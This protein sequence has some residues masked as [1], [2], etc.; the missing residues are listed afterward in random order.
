MNLLRGG[1]WRPGGIS[2]ALL[3]IQL[4]TTLQAAL[5]G[6]DYW[7]PAATVPPGVLAVVESTAPPQVWAG[8]MCGASLVVLLGL[9]GRWPAVLI[10]G[11]LMLSAVYLGVGLPVLSAVA[12]GPLLDA[13]VAA[14]A[15]AL[16]LWALL[17][18]RAPG[19]LAARL[20]AVLILAGAAV[21]AARVLGTDYRTG[22]GLVGAG[23]VHASLA[24]G[25][26]VGTARRR[27]AAWLEEQPCPADAETEVMKC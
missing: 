24:L 22:T 23:V 11:H 5:R 13:L 3:T 27:A 18:P 26:V 7:R 6:L 8:L 9:G 10:I 20:L 19:G 12:V 25:V 17:C 1:D 15:A 16:G 4:V 14:G 2:P 21:T